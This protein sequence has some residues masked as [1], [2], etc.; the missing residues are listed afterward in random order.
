MRS[1]LSFIL[2]DGA[3]N[4]RRRIAGLYALL[5][6]GN[7]LAWAWAL[8]VLRDYPVLLG[9]AALAY[10]FGLRHAVDADHIAAID[11]VTRTLM[12]SGKRPVAAGFFFSIGHSGG[13][14]AMT[15]AITIAAK[16]VET[17]F[18]VL[19]SVGEILGTCVSAFFLFAIAVVNATIFVSV[20]QTFRSVRSGKPFI[21]EDLNVL[22]SGRGLLA[23][24]FR[25]MFRLVSRSW[26][27][28]PIGLLFG[29]GFDTVTEVGLFG[30]SATQAADG[31]ALS[32]V[33]VFPV[34]F[35][36]AMALVDTTD[37]VLMVGA[38]GWAFTKPIRKLFYNM[39][40]TLVSAVVAI[41]IGGIE[42]LGLVADHFSLQGA[43]WDTIGVLND[44]WNMLGYAIIGVFVASWL[45]SLAIYRLKGYDQIEV[46][47]P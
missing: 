35:G 28:L 18:T 45:G 36:A 5:V 13:I 16:A 10:T 14:F 11:N 12:Q 20:Y 19:K 30:I 42:T 41:G 24:L 26:H 4:L 15:V 8:L 47:A 40:I 31:K 7:L 37:S 1:L 21:E 44:N 23:R 29:L 27:L 43:F 46:S 39:T 22:L 38:Y 2:S 32:V 34:L 33:L 25:P 3:A 9:T 6:A 17:R